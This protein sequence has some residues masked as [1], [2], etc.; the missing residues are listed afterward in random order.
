MTWT[1]KDKELLEGACADGAR[2]ALSLPGPRAVLEAEGNPDWTSWLARRYP[3]TGRALPAGLRVAGYLYLGGCTGLTALPAGLR[4]AGDLWLGGT[5]LGD[6][7]GAK[8]WMTL[9]EA[10]KALKQKGA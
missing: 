4:V 7:I 2:W 9:A 8:G 6:R 3:A 5:P 10:R 1:V